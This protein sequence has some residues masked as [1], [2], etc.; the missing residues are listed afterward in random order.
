MKILKPRMV[1]RMVMEMGTVVT[2][3]NG[4]GMSESTKYDRYDKEKKQF[5]G[6]TRE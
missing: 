3:G 5:A 4:G 2:N 1:R 6:R